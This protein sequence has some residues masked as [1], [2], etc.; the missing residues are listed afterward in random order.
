MWYH[1]NGNIQ[2]SRTFIMWLGYY[3]ISLKIPPKFPFLNEFWIWALCK[4]KR[5]VKTP[6][7]EFD[8]R[9]G[10]CITSSSGFRLDESRKIRRTRAAARARPISPAWYKAAFNGRSSICDWLHCLLSI[11]SYFAKIDTGPQY[12]QIILIKRNHFISWQK[13]RSC[14]SRILHN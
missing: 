10:G 7:T 6:R 12:P 8:L 13:S 4:F 2:I 11:V 14:F 5:N 9:V 3:Q 1:V